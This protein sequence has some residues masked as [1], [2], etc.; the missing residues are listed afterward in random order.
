MLKTLRIEHPHYERFACA[1]LSVAQY[2]GVDVRLVL[3]LLRPKVQ[4]R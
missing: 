2:A 4:Y 1:A 3:R